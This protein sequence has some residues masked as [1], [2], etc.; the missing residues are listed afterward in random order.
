MSL[1]TIKNVREEKWTELKSLAAR[2]RLPLGKMIEEMIDSYAKRTEEGWNRIL[3][4]EKHLSD[5]EAE[6]MRKI[7]LELRKERGFRE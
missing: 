6:D 5:R 2:N 1:K 3:K 7:V 4:G